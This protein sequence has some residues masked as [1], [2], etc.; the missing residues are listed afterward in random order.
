MTLTADQVYDL[1]KQEEGRFAVPAPYFTV[2]VGTLDVATGTF[3]GLRTTTRRNPEPLPHRP[4][5]HPANPAPEFRG[6]RWVSVTIDN[7]W[8]ETVT[9]VPAPVVPLAP[10]LLRFSVSSAPSPWSVKAAGV[11]TAPAGQMSL[12][13]NLWDAAGVTWTL[14]AGGVTVTD[15]LLIQRPAGPPAAA[16][17]AFTIPVLPVTIVYA[18]PADSPGLSTAS[19]TTAQTVGTSVDVGIGNETSTTVPVRA[20]GFVGQLQGFRGVLTADAAVLQAAGAG[21]IASGFTAAAGQ[22]GQVTATHQDTISDGFETTF[23]VTQSTT[24]TAGTT[25]AGGGPGQGD[26][27]HFVKD[28]RM[29]WAYADGDLRLCPLDETDVLVTARGLHGDPAQSGI[30]AADAASLLALDPFVSDPAAVPSPDRFTLVERL[31]YGHGATTVKKLDFT[32]DTKD[33][34][35]HKQVSTDTTTWDAGPVLKALGLGGTTAS[36][37]TLTNATGSDVSQTVTATA[38]LVS[39][40]DDYFTVNIWYD[41][42]FGTFAFQQ[43]PPTEEPRIAGTGATPGREV[44]LEAG[45]LEYRSVAGPEG[46]YQFRAPGIPAGQVTVTFA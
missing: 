2:D 27:L 44:V 23:T 20:T 9:S 42:L 21:S 43:L 37:Y 5:Q 6:N 22:L 10:V 16:V 25:A 29:V 18:P 41:A 33:Q 14:T 32:R 13:V 40:P 38:N 11:E 45:G 8:H 46:S 19:Y 36:S 26:V 39:G 31:E 30:T 15:S 24:D 12:L 4:G 7:S 3:T 34:V 35:T 17:G 1:I 28:L